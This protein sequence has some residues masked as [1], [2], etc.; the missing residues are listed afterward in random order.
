MVVFAQFVINIIYTYR[1]A[2]RIRFYFKLVWYKLVT[3]ADVFILKQ[4]ADKLIDTAF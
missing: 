2:A 1:Q 3:L 4:R